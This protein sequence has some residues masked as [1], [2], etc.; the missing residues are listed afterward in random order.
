MVSEYRQKFKELLAP[1][2][3]LSDE[4]LEGTFSNGLNPM[5]RAEMTCFRLAEI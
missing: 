3:Y 1:L 4:V 2:P 5:I